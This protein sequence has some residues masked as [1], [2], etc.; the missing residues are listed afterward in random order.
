M[1]VF[2]AEKAGR[3][4][5]AA[6]PASWGRGGSAAAAAMTA[7]AAQLPQPRGSAPSGQRGPPQKAAGNRKGA[8]LPKEAG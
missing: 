8:L 2:A 7:A 1:S 3:Q 5:Q 6:N 4:R